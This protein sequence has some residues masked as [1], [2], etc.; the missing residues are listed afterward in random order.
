MM[1]LEATHFRLRNSS[2]FAGLLVETHR[3]R[4]R[5]KQ[6]HRR[7]LTLLTLG[8]LFATPL[9]EAAPC[10]HG[11]YAG[12]FGLP[13][14]VRWHTT[15]LR[16]LLRVFELLVPWFDLFSCQVQVFLH[17][18]VQWIQR[19]HTFLHEH[20]VVSV[21]RLKQSRSDVVGTV[22][23]HSWIVR[24]K[25]LQRF[26]GSGFTRWRPIGTPVMPY[27]S[28]HVHPIQWISGGIG[29][30]VLHLVFHHVLPSSNRFIEISV[31]QRPVCQI[32]Q[33]FVLGF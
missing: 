30:D 29:Y 14:F 3:L 21:E 27:L 32:A 19:D 4:E 25:K 33:F 8:Y 1:F 5:I 18:S 7:T 23:A 6:L 15:S 20:L 31:R 13:T 17:H 10:S 24:F 2:P 11:P 26:L 9:T 16:K 12:S 28:Q 22:L